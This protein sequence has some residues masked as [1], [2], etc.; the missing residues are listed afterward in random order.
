[1]NIGEEVEIGGELTPEAEA[2][3]GEE[4]LEVRDQEGGD[5]LVHLLV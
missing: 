5:L 1:M 3:S 2:V 4:G